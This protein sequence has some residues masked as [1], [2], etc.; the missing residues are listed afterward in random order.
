V[1][2]TQHEF[3]ATHADHTEAANRSHRP[4][5]FERVVAAPVVRLCSTR[6]RTYYVARTWVFTLDVPWEAWRP[7][8]EAGLKDAVAEAVRRRFDRPTQW[9][10]DACLEGGKILVRVHRKVHYDAPNRLPPSPGACARAADSPWLSDDALTCRA[11][12]PLDGPADL[13]VLLSGAVRHAFAAC[14]ARAADARDAEAVAEAR[15]MLR[16]GL[17]ADV[18]EAGGFRGRLD[19]FNAELAA[20]LQKREASFRADVLRA[21]LGDGDSPASAGLPAGLTEAQ[22]LRACAEPLEARGAAVLPQPAAA[23]IR[24]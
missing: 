20:A 5:L 7:T 14:R 4:P 12:A 6:D 10:A 15:A 11:G 2:F 19:A 23:A 3:N 1:S 13:A 9:T 18:V 16:R 21:H 17:L 24:P 8:L 22:L